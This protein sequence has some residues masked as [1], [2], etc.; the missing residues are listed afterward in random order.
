MPATTNSDLPEQVRPFPEYPDLQAQD[1]PAHVALESHICVSSEAQVPAEKLTI[2]TDKKGMYPKRM[3]YRYGKSCQWC[4]Q[5]WI[6]KYK[7]LHEN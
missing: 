1:E 5:N 2:I 6:H 7:A 3:C 4:T